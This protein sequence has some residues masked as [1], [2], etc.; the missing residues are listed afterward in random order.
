MASTGCKR[1]AN[2]N[3]KSP[4]RWP[5]VFQLVDKNMN[6]VECIIPSLCC[7]GGGLGDLAKPC[8]SIF[9]ERVVVCAV[10]LP[11]DRDVCSFVS[12]YVDAQFLSETQVARFRAMAAFSFSSILSRVP[13]K[14]P[15]DRVPSGRPF[16][17]SAQFHKR[18]AQ[19]ASKLQNS[20]SPISEKES[21]NAKSLAWRV[22]QF[23]LQPAVRLAHTRF[24]ASGRRTPD[25]VETRTIRRK[26]IVVEAHA[27]LLYS[28]SFGML[29]IP[30][31]R[32][33]GR[34]ND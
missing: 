13:R 34:S 26:M 16:L 32:A 33:D 31:V 23:L 6:G 15:S 14:I 21:R 12:G 17:K 19:L 27:R 20:S 30:Q 22:V 25:P 7:W 11:A 8:S 2:P 18:P 29:R 1:G 4:Q 9:V 5:N 10:V 3:Q 24:C 28:I